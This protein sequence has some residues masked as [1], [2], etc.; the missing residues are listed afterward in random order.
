MLLFKA[1]AN[2]VLLNGKLS[3][4][5]STNVAVTVDLDKPEPSNTSPSLVILIFTYS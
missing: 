4:L 3:S 2:D 5:R 1:L